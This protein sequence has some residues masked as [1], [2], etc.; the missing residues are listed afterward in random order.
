MKIHFKKFLLSGLVII[1]FIFYAIYERL[2]NNVQAGDGNNTTPP[3]VASGQIFKDGQFIGTTADAYYGLVQVKAVISNGK[4]TDIIFLS[5]PKDRQ[6][7]V[8][9]NE[10]ALPV[11]KTEAIAAQSA[12]VNIVSG[13]TFTSQAFIAS[14]TAALNQASR[15]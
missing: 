11:L 3:P 13:A 2:G 5:Y 1:I 9:I 12:S 14:L 6:T 4:I 8:L 15:I 10:Q 7:S